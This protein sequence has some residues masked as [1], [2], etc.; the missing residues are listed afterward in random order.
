MLPLQF[1]PPLL[2]LLALIFF[3]SFFILHILPAMVPHSLKPKILI[4]ITWDCHSG[5]FCSV[6]PMW[7]C[8]LIHPLGGLSPAL[9]IFLLLLNTFFLMHL[10]CPVLIVHQQFLFHWHEQKVHFSQSAIT[11]MYNLKVNKQ[12]TLYFYFTS[13]LGI[14]LLF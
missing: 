6:C 1:P 4:F 13:I 8:T 5:W 3:H 7:I 10:A 2:Q 12:A 11:I 14:L 9:N